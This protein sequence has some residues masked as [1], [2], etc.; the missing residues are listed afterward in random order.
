MKIEHHD[1]GRHKILT[2][3]SVPTEEINSVIPRSVHPKM[4]VRVERKCRRGRL[5]VNDN[6]LNLVSIPGNIE[7]LSDGFA[8]GDI[9][10]TSIA[11]LSCVEFERNQPRKVLLGSP[12]E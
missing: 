4:D 1:P 7:A 2:I 6:I 9:A 3:E 5:G 12:C 11:V 8:D 10:D